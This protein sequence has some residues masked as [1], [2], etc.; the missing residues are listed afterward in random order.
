MVK[1]FFLA[2]TAIVYSG[3]IHAQTKVA[4]DVFARRPQ[5]YQGRTILLSQVTITTGTSG[6][7]NEARQTKGQKT[8]VRQDEKY[9]NFYASVVVP[10]RCQVKSGWTL[11]YPQIKGLTNPI[12]F[13]LVTKIHDRLPQNKTFNADIVIDVDVRGISQIKR[14]KVL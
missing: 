8:R 5:F 7:Q 11:V 12:C 1:T 14:I 2:F 9:W 6:N 3:L 10:P 13:A 4:T